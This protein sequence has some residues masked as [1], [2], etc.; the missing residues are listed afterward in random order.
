MEKTNPCT[1]YYVTP[2]KYMRRWFADK[3]EAAR[4]VLK[5][6]DDPK[7]TFRHIAGSTWQVNNIETVKEWAI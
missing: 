1:V 5:R 6:M 7:F 4:W 2:R 3:S